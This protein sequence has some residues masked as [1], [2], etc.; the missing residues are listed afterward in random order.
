MKIKKLFYLI[1]LFVIVLSIASPAAAFSGSGVAQ[2]DGPGLQWP[3]GT[4]QLYM[5]VITRYAMFA[6]SGQVKDSEDLPLA[7]VKVEIE[8]GLQA[9]TDANGVYHLTAPDGS[10]TIKASKAG[11]ELAPA[12]EELEVT[13]NM[14]NLNFSALSTSAPSVLGCTSLLINSNFEDAG[15]WQIRPAKNPSVAVN[16]HWFTPDTSMLSGVP[17]GSTNPFP[18][19]WTTGEFFQ[20]AT[21]AIP[22]NATVVQLRMH[23]LPRSTDLWGYHLAEQAAMDASSGANMPTATEAQYGFVCTDGSDT[24]TCNPDNGGKMLFKWFPINSYWWLWRSYDL[25]AFRGDTISILFGAAND[26]YNGNTA[27]YVDDVYLWYCTP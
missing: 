5:P 24:D 27:L 11:Y 10:Q 14:N 4:T 16:T 9:L 12:S 6:L 25:R 21:A 23:L 18:H 3:E 22:D 15:G 8:G 19:E 20:T 17:V 2:E 7:G 26:G 1:G 13:G